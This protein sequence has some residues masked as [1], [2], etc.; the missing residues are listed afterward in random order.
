MPGP[1]QDLCCYRPPCLDLMAPSMQ[2]PRQDLIDVLRNPT[3]I[4]DH[5]PRDPA[6]RRHRGRDTGSRRDGLPVT[7]PFQKI[8]IPAGSITR[9]RAGR[10]PLL[11]GGQ[12]NNPPPRREG[13]GTGDDR[14]KVRSPRGGGS[15]VSGIAATNVGL[16]VAQEGRAG[17]LIPRRLQ[18][19]SPSPLA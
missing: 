14:T 4:R 15:A 19:Q 16:H 13:S 5:N 1:H 11:S 9:S 18:V 10:W 3:T 8:R 17:W 6:L 7:S 2:R 12:E